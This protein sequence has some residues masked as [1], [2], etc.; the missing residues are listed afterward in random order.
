LFSI[1]F[2]ILLGI[3]AS[4]TAARRYGTVSDDIINGV[5]VVGLF[6]PEFIVGLIIFVVV[7][8]VFHWF[9]KGPVLPESY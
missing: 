6:I 7:L 4:T 2:I 3:T 5:S 8:N 9:P 1:A